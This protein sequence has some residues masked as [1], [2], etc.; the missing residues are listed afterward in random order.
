MDGVR[1]LIPISQTAVPLLVGA[2]LL[3]GVGA[4]GASA[5]KVPAWVKHVRH[6]DGGISNGVRARLAQAS[7]DI[8]VPT[9]QA[10]PRSALS[11]PTLDNVQMNGDSEPPLPQDEPSIAASLDDP[12]NAVAASNDYTGDGF[13]IGYTTDGGQAWTSQWKDPK[14]SFDG[15]R[16]FASDPSVVYSLRDHA[17]YLSTLCYFP[18]TPASEV[19]VWKSV[20]GGATWSS[21]LEPALVVT[22]HA[23]GGTI[24][25]SVF[26]DKELMAV[27]NTP[28]SPHFGRIY[29]TWTKFH[30]TG[31]SYARSD[32]CPVQAA[33]T[34]SIPTAD[35]SASV[36][37][38]TAIVSDAP[39]AKGVGASANQFSTPIVD[40]HGGLDVASCRRT[41]TRASIGRCSSRD[42]PTAARPSAGSCV[43]IN[44]A[45]SPTTRTRTTTCPA[46]VTCG[47]RTAPRSRTTR[48]AT[49]WR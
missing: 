24:D 39:G 36:W 42:P 28:S 9:Q 47:S 19:Q 17:F 32:Y 10:S 45:G 38:R 48:R 27:D 11:I 49:D 4:M 31:G 34:D 15:S 8:V 13:W 37:T 35:P 7:G 41:A 44:P 5:D 3:V 21:S 30:M 1:R 43:S 16:C 6:W 33:Y 25:A 12:M 2:A 46:K 29:V 18:T 14:F 20:D 40:D 22:N 26:H 23:S